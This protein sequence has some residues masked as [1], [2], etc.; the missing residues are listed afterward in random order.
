MYRPCRHLHERLRHVRSGLLPAGLTVSFI[1]FL[2]A[3]CAQTKHVPEGQTLLKRVSLHSTEK[4]FKA[5]AY[6]SCVRQEP[7]SKWFSLAKVP[8]A[9]YNLS[10]SD[11]TRRWNKFVR[12]IGEA[13]VCYDPYLTRYSAEAIRGAMQAKGYLHAQVRVD[14]LRRKR[15]MSVD[16]VLTPGVR[17]YLRDLHYTFDND[18]IRSIVLAD[19]MHTRLRIGHPFTIESLSAEQ[20]RIIRYLRARGYYM[21]NKEYI[22][23]TADTLAHDNAVTLTL[24]FARPAGLNKVDDY[25][26]YSLRDVNLYEDIEKADS[27]ASHNTYNGIGIN[28]SKRIKMYRRV[29]DRHIF[30]RP[31]SLYS[32]PLVQSTNSSLN[33][34]SAINYSNIRLHPV[35]SMPGQLDCDIH[36]RTLPPHTLGLELEGTNT[37]GDLGAAVA[38][39]YSNNNFLSGSELF[40]FKLRG[41]YEAIRG[42][43]GYSGQDYIEYGGEAN[44][45]FPVFRFPFLSSQKKRLLKASSELSLQYNSQNRPEF[46]RRVLTAGWSYKWQ[47]PLHP[48]IRHRL[49]MPSVN[50][51][52]MPWI[53][54]TFREEYLEGDDP[55]YAILRHS[56]ENLLIMNMA[57]S[58]TC[59]SHGRNAMGSQAGEGGYQLKVNVET[60]GNLLHGLARLASFHKDAS[61]RYNVMGIA[62]SQY[63]KFDVDY[64][65]SLAL[66][67][68]N[69]L[70][71]HVAVGLALP[72]ANSSIV[73]YEKRYFSG[74]ANS[75]RGWSVRGLGPGSYKGTDGRIDF[76]NQT[77]NLR[78]DLSMEY[79]TRLFW[80][81]AGAVF[82]DAGNVWNTRNYADQSGGQFRWNTFYKQI[83]VAYGIGLR[84]NL[85]YFVLRFDGGMKAVNPAYTTSR[86]H[87]PVIHPDF[88]RDFTFH[89]AVGL[90]F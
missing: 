25:R 50:Y 16:Y 6:R 59:Q 77:G 43:E 30:V 79:R 5:S 9:F 86:D 36:V 82:I 51:V 62:Y 18:T 52:F 23:Y 26:P 1:L 7:N 53:S 12:R 11:S 64:A 45:Q 37:S 61:G 27:T 47:N 65:H 28:Y 88:G 89:F 75:V 40:T 13:P 60:A 39:T 10:G 67:D 15:R 14:T 3:G 33:A 83:A 85:D 49:D 22:S 34:L 46:H 71:F 4:H 58:F 69:S 29:Y 76:I 56:Y 57:Y 74:G 38:L 44:L 8:L 17:Y 80:K 20:G 81:F 84:F 78:L 41:A 63:A 55:H 21:L 70:A 42:L 54:D 31:D 72:Y 19:T 90:P 73:P 35:D 24:C 68:R 32:E 48:Q 66:D 87:F 2:F